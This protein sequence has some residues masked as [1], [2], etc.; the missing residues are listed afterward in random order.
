M[1]V[2]T[3]EIRTTSRVDPNAAGQDEI[4]QD[5]RSG[6]QKKHA[7][8]GVG[9]QTSNTG[10]RPEAQRLLNS[11]VFSE[12]RL[13]PHRSQR[14]QFI[15]QYAGSNY[16]Q[17]DVSI[18][19][20]LNL[21]YSLVASFVPAL[22][23]APKATVAT[24]EGNAAFAETFRL[25]IDDELSQIKLDESISE[26]VLDSLF[27]LG[28]IKTGLKAMPGF[29]DKYDLIPDAG[30][31]FS[32]QVSF[33]DY[34]IDMTS[35]KRRLAQYEGD[36]FFLSEDIARESGMF[37][38]TQIQQLLAPMRSRS[39]LD[40]GYSAGE[41][42]ASDQ[43]FIRRL[44]LVNVFLP[45]KQ[46]VV[47]IP[48]DVRYINAGFLNQVDWE[49]DPSGPYDV[50]GFNPVPDNMLPVPVVG[51][52]FDL[53]TLLNKLGRKIGRQADRQK[54]IAVGQKG[55]EEDAQAI[56]TSDDG[57]I[58]LIDEPTS[59]KEVSF[60]GANESSYKTVAWL[61]DYANTIAGNPNLIGG[62][63]ADSD[64]LGQDQLKMN[65]ASGR[66][67]DWLRT[68]RKCSESIVKKL[69]GYVWTDPNKRRTLTLKIGG[70]VNGFKVTRIWDPTKREGSYH[71]Y[72]VGISSH[73]HPEMSPEQ[74]YT[75][76]NAWIRDVL[77]NPNMV[78]AAQQQGMTLNV[79]R[80][81]Q[82]TGEQL[83]IEDAANMFVPVEQ[84]V[85][86]KQPIR[87]GGR[88]GSGAKVD[89]STKISTFRSPSGQRPGRQQ[90]P[91]NNNEQTPASTE[92]AP[93]GG[94]TGA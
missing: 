40:T 78:I 49:G 1:V 4:I 42:M 79:E 83:D 7:A 64:T 9:V 28:I 6:D 26:A 37:N 15:R 68:I 17:Q 31:I 63:N 82:I 48:G 56:R 47:T 51:A 25:A 33:A 58:V 94:D 67:N 2:A 22:R 93:T 50:I 32:E 20:P 76:I 84:I 57:D 73:N 70:D 81:A 35:R 23:F 52:V 89:N 27:G 80:I 85:E 59:I 13:Q 46:Q 5:T 21:V 75:R 86:Q 53:Y 77:S 36:R 54:D 74:E 88:A 71:D 14:T 39:E 43:E 92:S 72:T 41:G 12:K 60:G 18:R 19:D 45:G 62:V 38:E 69:G 44:E 11:I 65:N 87:S 24:I 10:G 29:S 34:I 55:R 90:A 66:I 3:Q 30:T 61:D 8:D 91:T 16:G